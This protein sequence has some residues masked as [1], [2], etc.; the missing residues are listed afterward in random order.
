MRYCLKSSIY[1]ISID[2]IGNIEIVVY[3]GSEQCRI[4]CKPD[5]NNSALII[6]GNKFTKIV[7]TANQILQQRNALILSTPAYP[8]GIR[9]NI[10]K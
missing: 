6:D 8:I 3:S 1:N 7:Q 2:E 4:E 9:S 5:D 10:A